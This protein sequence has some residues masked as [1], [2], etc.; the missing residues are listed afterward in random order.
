[1]G[2]GREGGGFM[3]PRQ[4]RGAI[5]DEMEQWN[6][7]GRGSGGVQHTGAH[8]G[9][10]GIEQGGQSGWQQ[11]VS[12]RQQQQQQQQQASAASGAPS[13][14]QPHRTAAELK[15]MKDID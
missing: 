9:N 4:Q 7:I 1:M 15:W 12:R 5:D 2:D 13:T 10:E 6:Y 3:A 14:G 8:N 11:Q